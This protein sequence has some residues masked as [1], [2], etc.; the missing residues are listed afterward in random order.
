MFGFMLQ[1]TFFDF[2]DNALQLALANLLITVFAV[3]LASV[4]PALAAFSPALALISAILLAFLLGVLLSLTSF[5][6]NEIAQFRTAAPAQ[7]PTLLKKSWKYGLFFAGAWILATLLSTVAIPFYTSQGG[8]LGAGAA[9]IVFWTTVLFALALHLYLPTAAQ[10]ES[11]VLKSL[12]KSVMILFDNALFIIQL[13]F[14]GL[15]FLGLS[16]ISG[17]LLFGPAG[18]LLL[19][20]I[21]VKLR[22]YKYD[23]LARES[24]VS[25]RQ[26]HK[27]PWSELIREDRSRVY[28]RNLKELFFPWRQ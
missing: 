11:G 6:T 15:I 4:P 23:Y 3:A 22:L 21:A 1:K 19:Y 28:V 24:E 8:M 10:L 25:T 9:G 27:I 17:F 12:T 14:I 20:N 16:A 18:I 2:W 26:K 5:Y 7:L 13:F